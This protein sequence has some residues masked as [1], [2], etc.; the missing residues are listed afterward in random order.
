[1]DNGS[2]YGCRVSGQACFQVTLRVSGLATNLRGSMFSRKQVSQCRS[3]Q[4]LKH[5]RDVSFLDPFPRSTSS[6]ICGCVHIEREK[7]RERERDTDTHLYMH[8]DRYMIERERDDHRHT[9][10]LYI[11]SSNLLPATLTCTSAHK[12]FAYKMCVCICICIYRCP[13]RYMHI[14]RHKVCTNTI[15]LTCTCTHTYK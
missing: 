8:I 14:C 1:M 2:S 7:E 13:Y 11:P 3:I 12:V 10:E 6:H 15:C 5:G 4:N 9:H